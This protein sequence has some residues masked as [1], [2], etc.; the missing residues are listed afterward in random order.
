MSARYLLLCLS[1]FLP[2]CALLGETENPRL[3]TLTSLQESAAKTLPFSLG[4]GP[5]QFPTYLDQPQLLTRTRANELQVHELHRW[6]GALPDAFLRT[7]AENLQPASGKGSVL[8]Y[9]WDARLE[10][11]YQIVLAVQRFDG[12]LGGEVRLKVRWSLLDG[13]RREALLNRYS[14]I[15][16]SANGTSHAALVDAHSAA[17]AELS[18]EM[19]AAVKTHLGK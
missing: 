7:L 5:V 13:P 3:Y 15:R 17:L 12:Y 10:P 9:P 8:T 16:V 18:R 2:G 4:L 1:L 11:A 14:D 19:I 6:V